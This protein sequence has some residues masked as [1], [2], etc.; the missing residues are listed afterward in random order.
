MKVIIWTLNILITIGIG[1]RTMMC[2]Q[3][4]TSHNIYYVKLYT[5]IS[6]YSY[7]LV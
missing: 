5:L 2:N 1:Q 7:S 3:H 6:P 4:I